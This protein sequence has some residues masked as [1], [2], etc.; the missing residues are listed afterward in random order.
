LFIQTFQITHSYFTSPLICPIQ[1][2]QYHSPSEKNVILGARG[3]SCSLTAAQNGATPFAHIAPRC[4][5]ARPIQ[6]QKDVGYKSHIEYTTLPSQNMYMLTSVKHTSK[7]IFILNMSLGKLVGKLEVRICRDF[8]T[9]LRFFFPY[10][11]K[12][13]SHSW[14][15]L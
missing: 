11:L 2:S 5:P 9:R 3:L 6:L 10:H 13:P 12:R 8:Q 14:I 15:Q 1:L 7:L 4:L